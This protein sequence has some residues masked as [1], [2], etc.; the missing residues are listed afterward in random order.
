MMSNILISLLLGFLF[1]LKWGLKKHLTMRAQYQLWYPF[2]A[3]MILPILPCNIIPTENIWYRIRG[4]FLKTVP[5]S[6]VV[7]STGKEGP[8]LLSNL[9]VQD[10]SAAV[11]SSN[12]RL[13]A[14]LCGM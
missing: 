11:I 10:F 13:T 12:A 8:H 1:L 6:A 7:S 9:T 3:A 14:L 4:F 5:E 2:L